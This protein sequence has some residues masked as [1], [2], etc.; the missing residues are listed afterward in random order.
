MGVAS[1]AVGDVSLKTPFF[2]F[3]LKFRKYFLFLRYSERSD[4]SFRRYKIEAIFSR[5]QRFLGAYS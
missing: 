2:S 5:H 4:Q 3:V 1:F